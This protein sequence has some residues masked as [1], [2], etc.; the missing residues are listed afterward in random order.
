MKATNVRL[1]DD[2]RNACGFR[3]SKPVRKS[4]LFWQ[5][6]TSTESSLRLSREKSA[7]ENPCD[8]VSV[9]AKLRS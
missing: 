8:L 4:R 2:T 7:T 9:R 6:E 1:I 5:E 3:S